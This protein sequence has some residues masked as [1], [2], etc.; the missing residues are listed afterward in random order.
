MKTQ[1]NTIKIDIN[2]INE[3]MFVEF[4]NID[5]DFSDVA[6]KYSKQVFNLYCDKFYNNIYL[7]V[8]KESLKHCIN[9]KNLL[10]FE[11]TNFILNSSMC[12]DYDINIICI[13]KE[14]HIYSCVI[15]YLTN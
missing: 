15:S 2:G 8:L 7:D 1:L 12:I 14:E 3:K 5:Q 9:M 11:L 4:F 6:E 13:N 10:P